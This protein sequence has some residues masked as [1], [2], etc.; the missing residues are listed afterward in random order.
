VIKCWSEGIVRMKVGE[1]ALL[2]CPSELAYGDLGQAPTVPGGAAL[3]FEVELV[4]L[5][6]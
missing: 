4:G 1:T 2:T 3:A 6:R 5:G